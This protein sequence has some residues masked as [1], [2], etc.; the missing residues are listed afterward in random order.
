MD[1]K[2]KEKIRPDT[3]MSEADNKK[4]N[5]TNIAQNSE[6]S[7]SEKCTDLKELDEYQHAIIKAVYRHSKSVLELVGGL[8]K[9]Q[10]CDCKTA[11]KSL[12]AQGLITKADGDYLVGEEIEIRRRK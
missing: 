3:A 9:L 8:Q 11:V 4:P 2:I 6:K 5:S 12:V 1:N 10:F 7:K